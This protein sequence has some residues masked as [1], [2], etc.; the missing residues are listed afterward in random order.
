MAADDKKRYEEEM[1]AYKP[2]PE[3]LAAHEA[4][5]PKKA[6]SE[7]GPSS[8]APPTLAE[9][10]KALKKR[11]K[12]LESQVAKQEKKI[13]KLEAKAEKAAEKASTAGKRKAKDDDDKAAKKSGGKKAKKED[14][15]DDEDDEEDEDEG[16]EDEG[17]YE[18]WC[19]KV[20]GKDGSKMD[21]ELQKAYESKGEA[22]LMKLLAKRYQK[23]FS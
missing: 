1:A 9:E 16:E 21:K 3:F 18:E 20:L 13:E 8:A 4:A 11:V 15:E 12:E 19:E 22:G 10:N 14:D 5:K 2:S 7:A 6:G 17:H 23:E